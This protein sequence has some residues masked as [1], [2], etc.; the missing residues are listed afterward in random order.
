MIAICVGHSRMG[1]MGAL[2]VTGVSEWHY[3]G[4]IAKRV[5]RKLM[6]MDCDA[7]VID[8]YPR[9]GY[10]SAMEWLAGDLNRRGVVCA[11]E[12]H[13]NSSDNPLSHG[14]EWLHWGASAPSRALA[15]ALQG[16]MVTAFPEIRS[17]GL[18]SIET[19]K[20]RGGLFLA[21]TPCPAV[22][23]EPFF[24]S[25]RGEWE[26]FAGEREAYASALADGLA[27]WKG[28]L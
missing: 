28:K 21:R 10:A 5:R 7:C 23:A 13:F 20:N 11:V 22:I 17:R 14:H 3:N 2:S 24:G 19:T 4:D 8:K 26:L 25:N 16:A 12:L 27:K 6:E 1:D 18:V 15:Q 9:P